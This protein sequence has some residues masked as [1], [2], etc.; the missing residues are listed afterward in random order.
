MLIGC[1]EVKHEYTVQKCG[2]VPF[3]HVDGKPVRSRMFYSNVP[4]L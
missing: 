2:E 4:G 3:L 1:K